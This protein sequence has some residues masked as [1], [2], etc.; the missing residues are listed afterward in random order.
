MLWYNCPD[1]P[2]FIERG[3]NM[4]AVE[5]IKYMLEKIKSRTD[6]LKIAFDRGRGKGMQI[7]KWILIEM[8]AGL[9]ELKNQNNIIGIEG[10]HKYN[11]KFN[12]EER[13]N[14]RFEQC[15]LWWQTDN[16]EYWLEVKTI[17]ITDNWQLGKYEDIK[18]DIEKKNRIEDFGLFYHMTFV[19]YENDYNDECLQKAYGDWECIYSWSYSI[20]SSKK[21][22]IAVYEPFMDSAKSGG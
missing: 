17:V 7:E 14:P 9:K 16:Q 10:E 8:L 21:L 3:T 5:I 13:K 22:Y 4:F 1:I 6:I 11:S 20:E 19:F 2:L 18:T 12:V 15:D